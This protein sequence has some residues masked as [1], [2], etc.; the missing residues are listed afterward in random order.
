MKTRELLG[1]IVCDSIQVTE[2]DKE[3]FRK[4]EKQAF[5]VSS[6]SLEMVN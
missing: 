1:G 5:Q 3:N 2:F 6:K 4:N